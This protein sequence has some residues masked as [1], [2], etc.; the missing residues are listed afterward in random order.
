MSHHNGAL[1]NPLRHDG[2]LFDDLSEIVEAR[3]C[4]HGLRLVILGKKKN[5][6]RT[7]CSVPNK[8]SF[9]PWQTLQTFTMKAIHMFTYKGAITEAENDHHGRQDASHP[10]QDCEQ[11]GHD[12]IFT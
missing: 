11:N 1:E 5:K 9:Q 10:T 12:L 8:S 2:V 4:A 7:P 3:R 6:K